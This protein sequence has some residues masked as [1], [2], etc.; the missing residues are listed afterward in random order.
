MSDRKVEASHS[1]RHAAP[2]AGS[3][4]ESFLRAPVAAPLVPDDSKPTI[5]VPHELKGVRHE[6]E[7]VTTD[8]NVANA[9]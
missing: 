5:T 6:A 3:L 8:G 4:C 2:P 1:D 9:G 7:L